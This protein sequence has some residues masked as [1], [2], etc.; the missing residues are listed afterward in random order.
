MSRRSSDFVSISVSP[1]I[2]LTFEK[3]RSG[4]SWE[5]EEN[6]YG[7]YS[8]LLDKTNRIRNGNRFK[9]RQSKKKNGRYTCFYGR[10]TADTSNRNTR[11][12]VS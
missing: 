4:Y 5:T 3:K 6:S 12:C 1:A 11:S 9:I 8:S 7:D 10:I 2:A